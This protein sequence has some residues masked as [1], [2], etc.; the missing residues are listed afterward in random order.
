MSTQNKT[1]VK[2]YDFKDVIVTFGGIP[3]SGYEDGTAIEVAPSSD[4][5]TKKVGADGEVA[6]GRSNDDTAEVK[7][8]LMQTSL[9]NTYLNTFL[10]ADRLANAGA[11]PLH[12]MDVN[13]GS[14]DFFPVAWVKKAP[15]KGYAKEV[16]PREWIFDTGQLADEM[17]LGDYQ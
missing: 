5:F 16:G 14:L 13:G 10:K 7:L 6:R 1:D 11:K 17:V 12:I 4:R 9:S 2:T 3:I 15:V 8:I